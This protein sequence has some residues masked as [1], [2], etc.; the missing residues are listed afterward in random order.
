MHA[1]P[2][3]VIDQATRLRLDGRGFVVLGAGRGIG[4]Q[5]CHALSQAGAGLLCVDRD[6]TA[7]QHV[8]AEVAGHALAADVTQRDGMEAV[9]AAARHALPRLSGI[10]DIVGRARLGPMATLTDAEYCEQH[11]VVFRHAWL[12]IQLGAPLLAAAGGGS[13]VVVGSLS[14]EAALPH[15]V[16]YGAQKA[17]LH[18]LVRCAAVEYAP[19]GVRINTVAPGPTRTPRLLASLG[20]AWPALEQSIPLR[21]GAD[22]ADIASA[23]LFLASDMARCITAQL[24]AV[25][26][27]A[28]A[29]VA[30][31]ASALPASDFVSASA[32]IAH[33]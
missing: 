30:R 31:P 20:E 25:D 4:R 21:R 18:H 3:A 27:G 28:L 16:L 7:A 22:P 2:D 6:A 9:F 8:A 32:S 33:P 11:Q 19:Q 24:I 17:A 5:V 1:D 26:G 12:A 23:V 10:V 14:G 13:I 15:Q 29:T